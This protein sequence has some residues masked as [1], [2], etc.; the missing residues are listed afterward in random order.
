[1]YVRILK[2]NGGTASYDVPRRSGDTPVAEMIRSDHVP[3]FQI[4]D[5]VYT[6][7]LEALGED[8]NERL[9]DAAEMYIQNHPQDYP[10]FASVSEIRW[11]KRVEPE[12]QVEGIKLIL[13]GIPAGLEQRGLILSRGGFTYARVKVLGGAVYPEEGITVSVI[14]DEGSFGGGEVRLFA[15]QSLAVPSLEKNFADGA[16]EVIAHGDT[17]RPGESL[18]VLALAGESATGWV[19]VRAEYGGYTSDFRVFVSADGIV[20]GVP[21]VNRGELGNSLT[22]IAW[23]TGETD[24]VF[25][26]GAALDGMS[27]LGDDLSPE[28]VFLSENKRI[29]VLRYT[30]DEQTAL[31]WRFPAIETR[32]RHTPPAGGSGVQVKTHTVVKRPQFFLSL[33]LDTDSD[34]TGVVGDNPRTEEERE[35]ASPMVRPVGER[36]PGLL[37]AVLPSYAPTGKLSLVRVSGPGVVRVLMLDEAGQEQVLL[38][39]DQEESADIFAEAQ[40]RGNIPLIFEM[41]GEGADAFELRYEHNPF[42]FPVELVVAMSIGLLA[43]TLDGIDPSEGDLTQEMTVTLSGQN[44]QHVESVL[45]Y[46]RGMTAPAGEQPPLRLAPVPVDP[47]GLS[48]TFTMPTRTWFNANGYSDPPTSGTDDPR[49]GI[50]VWTENTQAGG[51]MQTLGTGQHFVVLPAE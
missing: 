48:V 26:G 33:D 3:S 35:V 47:N 25:T 41:T 15:D 4:N 8:T 51:R 28:L 20:L 45:L 23:I 7:E 38:D 17:D 9:S 2:T 16:T 27:C 29:M 50:T 24:A 18:P 43:P 5:R 40:A 49:A 14:P 36:G 34:N 37:R 42:A 46:Y 12:V 6:D 39:L 19:T 32:R 1:M 21:F 22:V 44:L 10:D 31:G 30:M 13:E 11:A